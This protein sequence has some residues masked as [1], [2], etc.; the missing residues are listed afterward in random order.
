MCKVILIC[1][2]TG[3]GKTVYANKLAKQLNAVIMSQDE[4]M[5]ELFTAEQYYN[6]PLEYEKY[7]SKVED[8]LKHKA[9]AIAICDHGFWRVQNDK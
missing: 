4:L 9:G 8:Y 2:K 3:S 7:Y 1:G 6:E 5:L